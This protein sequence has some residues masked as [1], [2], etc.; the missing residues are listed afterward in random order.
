MTLVSL[1]FVLLSAAIHVGWNYLTKTSRDPSV[2][3]LLKGM[4]MVAISP[5]ALAALPLSLI[6]SEIWVYVL[7]SGAIHGLYILA[8]SK[9]YETGDIS[10]VYPIARSAPALVPVAA[11]LFI[12]EVIPLQGWAGIMMVVICVLALQ[13][14]GQARV[15]FHRIRQNLIKRDSL[16]AF[17]TLI[18]VVSYSLVDKAAMV[19]LSD[20]AVIAPAMRGPGFFMLQVVFCYLLFGIY[21]ATRGNLRLKAAWSRQWPSIIAAAVGT[22]ASYS[23]ILH[24]LQTTPVSYVVSVRQSSVLLAVF[25]GWIQLKEP[26]GKFRL[27]TSILM[28][29]GLVLVVTATV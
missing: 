29:I 25:I 11:F 23:L 14:R 27:V 28:V 10:Y 16:W 22:M 8:L 6:P 1:L 20:V 17:A 3:S 4:T 9:A 7:I 21:L 24:V 5:V 13:F 2:F 26:Y 15:D 19:A 12:G 18:A